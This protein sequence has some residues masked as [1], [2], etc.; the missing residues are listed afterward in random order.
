M[1]PMVTVLMPCYNAGDYLIEAL[2]SVYTQTYKRWKIIL[3]DDASTDNSLYKARKYVKNP[4]VTIIRNPENLG[5][6]KSQNIGL[7]HVD[8]SYVI[9]LD[10]DDWFYP[11]TLE[12]LVREAEN[13]PQNVGIFCGN[14]L[15]YYRTKKG[16]QGI[17]EKGYS[18]KNKY[19]FLLADCTLR[20]RFYRT[21]ALKE[22]GGWPTDDQYE[23]RY[24]ED[25]RILL[26]MIENYDL[27]WVD[28][29]LYKYRRHS[30]NMTRQQEIND[31]MIR[32]IHS[33][34]LKRWGDEYEAVYH[35]SDD[36]WSELVKLVPKGD[37]QTEQR[38]ELYPTH[39]PIREKA[40]KSLLKR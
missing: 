39:Q 38:Q 8:T 33:D 3:I 15:Y 27:H 37:A 10:S 22:V 13:Q 2:E 4:R 6:S 30:K 36:G 26:R 18:Y 1:K 12:V 31:E 5:Q 17:I 11:E 14:F 35:K 32:W 9:Q 16:W 29:L 21:D 24:V 23:G 28:Q 40:P 34:A 7:A 25:R 20:P 19:E